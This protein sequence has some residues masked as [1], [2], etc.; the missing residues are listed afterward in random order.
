[1][2]I[3]YGLNPIKEALNANSRE[4]FD[5][6]A[7]KPRYRDIAGVAGGIPVHEV[8]KR[9][10]DKITGTK[11]HQGVAARVSGYRYTTLEDVATLNVIVLLDSVE[12]PQNLGAIIRS[13]HALAGSGIIIPAKRAASV[14]PSVLKASAGATEYTKIAR[15]PNLRMAAKVLKGQG[16]WL[17]GLEAEKGEQI[18]KIPTFERLGVV[19][20]GE[21]AGIR[22]G[23]RSEID[24]VAHIPMKTAFNSLN[25]A[26][27][28]AIAMY[29]L[30]TRRAS[31]KA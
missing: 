8:T 1:M 31:N 5:V 18:G 12:D 10:L 23:M 7:C 19:L 6:V 25:V 4:F 28:A 16:F 20:G 11:G 24:V 17:V 3:I 27:S 9:E 2:E 30:V 21:D 14:T 13:A 15:V 22:S 26:S 29:E